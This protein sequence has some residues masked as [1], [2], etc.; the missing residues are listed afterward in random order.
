MCKHQ[1]LTRDGVHNDFISS[2]YSLLLPLFAGETTPKSTKVELKTPNPWLN[3][4][5]NTEFAG[6]KK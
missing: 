3:D 6:G 5:M 1:G 2:L 4:E